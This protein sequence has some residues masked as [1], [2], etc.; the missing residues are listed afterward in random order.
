[1]LNQYFTHIAYW[2]HFAPT[3]TTSNYLDSLNST[4]PYSEWSPH[5]VTMS[6]WLFVYLLVSLGYVQGMSDLLAPLLFVT[7]NEVE[8]FWCLTGFMELVVSS[9]VIS[10]ILMIVHK[11]I[12]LIDLK[13]NVSGF[14]VLCHFLH[15]FIAVL[16]Y[17]SAIFLCTALLLIE[18]PGFLWFKHFFLTMS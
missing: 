12:T 13:E 5:M 15:C 18:R 8:S 4:H 7:Q 16:R 11:P 14:D 9:S 3:W 1:M 2:H 17:P 10:H 6:H